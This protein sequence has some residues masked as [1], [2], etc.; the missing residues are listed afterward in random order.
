M[1]VFGTRAIRE[2]EDILL[3]NCLLPVPHMTPDGLALVNV[4]WSHR[5]ENL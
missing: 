2:A 4:A 1:Q 5:I 3:S